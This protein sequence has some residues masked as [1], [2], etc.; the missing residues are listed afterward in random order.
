MSTLRTPGGNLNEPHLTTVMWSPWAWGAS[1]IRYHFPGS[2]MTIPSSPGLISLI[3]SPGS[4]STRPAR[5]IFVPAVRAGGP[6]ELSLA[7]LQ[8]SSRMTLSSIMTSFFR[9]LLDVRRVF[10][11]LYPFGVLLLL[12][13]VVATVA[14]NDGYVRWRQRSATLHC[15][16]LRSAH[17]R[18]IY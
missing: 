2:A 3:S 5:P 16:A 18:W 11:L 14:G 12:L 4:S 10:D 8:L 6:L 15:V 7:S 17:A 9:L 1:E 13:P